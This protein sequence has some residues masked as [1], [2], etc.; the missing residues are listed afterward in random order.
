MHTS[1][2]SG[3]IKYGF[4]DVR[5]GM[6]YEEKAF[7]ASNE[8]LR[9]TLT[10]WISDGPTAGGEATATRNQRVAKQ[11][12]ILLDTAANP[13]A[14]TTTYQYD[15][16]LNVTAVTQCE[17]VSV[18]D[19]T[20]AQ[21]AGIS[22]AALAAGPAMRTVDTTYLVND[23]SLTST[24]RD[25]YRARHMI[26]LPTVVVTKNSADTRVA[27]SQV[28]Y[29]ESAYPLLSYTSVSGWIDPATT[30]RGNVTTSRAWLD[31]TN[32][33]IETHVQYDKLGNP[34]N[35]WDALGHL[36]Q[37]EYDSVNSYAYP[38]KLKT[39]VPDATGVNGQSAELE[40][41]N[42]FDPS[43]GLLTSSTDPNG[44]ITTYGYSDPLNRL[45]SI[46]RPSGG[47]STT[48]S[49]SDTPGT[50]YVRTQT[51][52]DASRVLDGYQYFDGLG[53]P[54]RSF[55]SEGSGY[56]VSDT[57]YDSMLRVL[58]VSN[59]YRVMLRTDEIPQSVE[60][61]TSLYDALGRVAFV[62]TPDNAVVTSTYSANQVTVTDQASKVRTSTADALGRLVSVVEAPNSSNYETTYGYDA[63]DNLKTVTQGTQP[64]RTF[65]YDSLKRL[66]RAVNPESGTVNYTYFANSNL[67][68]KVD[69]RSITTTYGYDA[70]SR[71]ISRTYSGETVAT[72]AVTYKYDGAGVAGGVDYAK[73]KLTKV[74]SSVSG[75]SYDEY[76]QM[77]R[78]KRCKQTTGGVDYS[79]S[80]T[81]D[82]AGNKT[83]EV[84]PSLRSIS[85]SYDAAG[86]QL[87][88]SGA[89]KDYASAMS[90][91]PHGAMASMTLGNNLIETTG[92]NNRLQPTLIRLGS[93]SI[94]ASVIQL[95]YEYATSGHT[96]NNGNVL[97][98][99]ITVGTPTAVMT[100]A[101]SYDALNR[102]LTATETGGWTQSYDYDRWGNRGVRAGSH[103]PTARQTPTST[104]T[105]LSGLFNQ[106]NNRIKT[107]EYAYDAVGNLT[108]MPDKVAGPSN[109][110][111]YD[112]EN[113]QTT[114]NGTV[115]QYFY[116]G[117]GRRV[118]KIDSSGTT[119]FVY[120]AEG[121]LIAEYTSGPAPGGGTSYLTSD[122]LGSTRVVTDGGGA[123]KARHDYLP[124][125]EELGAGV[126][127]RSV[128]MKYDAPDSTKQRFTQKERDNESGLDYFGARYYSGPQG[129][130]TSA[131]PML[132]SG[133]DSNPQSW[134]R[135]V[136]VFNNPMRW[137]DPSGLDPA[138]EEERKRQ[139][140]AQAKADFE[141]A[142]KTIDQIV[143]NGGN[144]IIYV[145]GF[146]NPN[147]QS[148]AGSREAAAEIMNETTGNVVSASNGSG[149]KDARAS[150]PNGGTAQA[151][152][153]IVKYALQSG[154]KAGEISIIAHSNGAPSLAQ[155]LETVK[156]DLGS[157]V[158]FNAIKLYA[159]NTSD[160]SVISRIGE[161]AKPG[162]LTLTNSTRDLG[163]FAADYFSSRDANRS[164]KEWKRALQNVDV[165]VI[166]T[167]QFTHAFKAYARE[168]LKGRVK[169]L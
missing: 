118:K 94:P 130:F 136:Y 89:G 35:S 15:Q 60:W 150:A 51:D 151:V 85:T 57:Q 101:Y 162:G 99:T 105:D 27:E 59:P 67:F 145:A 134:N 29:D 98:Q 140:A 14:K 52:L 149:V 144:L 28:I 9:R 165:Q 24:V 100:Q 87:K 32:T 111:T 124:F 113:R 107:A 135:Y 44:Q 13:L 156:N 2:S 36:S 126:G 129:R 78:L 20:T 157:A 121:Q 5:A 117:D 68:T 81:W 128:A 40:T 25:A 33:F 31:T 155:G 1:V 77:G 158:Q 23:T 159:P 143:K 86:R 45:K 58:R 34:R 62:A 71:V 92:F 63:L 37:L 48:I 88:V 22:A 97:K 54:I 166:Q 83:G 46:V 96:D 41:T 90:Y 147:Q 4:D 42:V 50:F 49:Y 84:Y 138:D 30:N 93:A 8:M 168:E 169:P 133:R 72:P 137:V 6:V 161:F 74:S 12:E 73:G 115:G 106:A 160:V 64:S 122:H 75:Y 66:T 65:L 154:L 148:S 16:D 104:S 19:L 127:S 132:S 10:K 38:T 18:V 146:N 109:M 53:R 142:K 167:R 7:S 17:F 61:T 102:L 80:Y 21:T 56:I 3:S 163:L 108:S 103:I 82:L 76:D 95:G 39:P 153:D 141:V 123:V 26:A 114:F 79:M 43:T 164:P 120:N 116:D 69:G 139:A 55:I 70:L 119:V 112:A 11:V 125:G 152:A 47:G 131:D 91:A 110:M